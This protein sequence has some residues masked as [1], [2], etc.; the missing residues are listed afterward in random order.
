MHITFISS[1]VPRKCGIATYTR[2]LSLEIESQKNH[3]AVVAM[4]NPLVP[5]SYT[6]PVISHIRQ[7]K[8][9]DYTEIAKK[10]NASPTDIVHIQHEFGLFGG[11]YGDDI[12]MLAQKLTKPLI[13]TFHT[14]LF[15][16][17]DHQKYILQEL[18]RL[19]RK[20]VVMEDIAKDRLENVYGLSREDIVVIPHGTPVINIKKDVAKKSLH[21]SD[22]FLLLA[23]NLL[24]RRMGMEYAI[25]AVA[26]AVTV[27]PNLLFLIV[28]ET[29]PVVKKEEGESYRNELTQL[30]KKLKLEK[31]VF[32]INKYVSLDELKTYLSAADV[33]ITPYLDPQQITSGALAY[34]IGA[35]KACIATEYVYAKEMLGHG[36]GIL[37]PFQ[38]SHAIATSLVEL[39]QNPE[40]RQKIEKRLYKIRQ[41][42]RWSNVAEKHIILYKNSLLQKNDI[43]NTV[44]EFLQTPLDISHLLHMTDNVGLLQHAYHAIPDRRFGY[45]TDDNT[46]ALI[47]IAKLYKEKRSEDIS[48]LLKTY[49][50]FLQYAQEP[51][52]MFH[53]FLTFQH[54]WDD[55]PAVTDAYG[56]A[57]WSLGYYLYENKQ[58]H[59]AQPVQTFFLKSLQCID[60]INDLR[61][62]AYA[63]LGLYYYISAYDTKTDPSALAMAH[64]KRLANSLL[65]AYKKFHDNTWEWF[66]DSLTYDNFRLPQAMFAAYLVTGN[67]EYKEVAISTLQ[68]LTTCN[69]DKKRGYYDFVGQN[70]WH[71]KGQKKADYDQQPLEAAGAIGAYLFASQALSKK[72]YI[73]KALLVFSWFFGNNRNHRYIYD[74]E[75]KGVYDGLNLRGVNQNQGA[76]SLVSFLMAA[77][78][79]QEVANDL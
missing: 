75:T 76:E 48:H 23:N 51:N 36:R 1:F 59:F 9:S 21:M 10:L 52:G 12:L 56:K 4:D 63:M 7:N 41:D 74:I 60:Q 61:A 37:V 32:I 13:S 47:V 27:I 42:M 17:T 26:Q 57:L 45:S 71:K 66:E 29:H 39:Y 67:E 44:K 73:E 65:D 3:I 72:E 62:G 77:L 33:Y 31:H 38:D 50:S 68:F 35:D 20:V 30:V 11:V 8:R 79:L 46:R 69:F 58:S 18:A 78:A 24:S 19:S 53:T 70:G 49:L 14:V 43:N 5:V 15:T 2:D 54:T 64:I 40:K 16:P 22:S 6:S 55:I 25:N 34:A 28:G